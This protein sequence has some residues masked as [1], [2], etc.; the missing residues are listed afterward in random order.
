MTGRMFKAY[1]APANDEDDDDDTSQ[2]LRAPAYESRESEKH[3]EE[4]RDD[5]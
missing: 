1:I 3:A 4:P 5:A 2:Q